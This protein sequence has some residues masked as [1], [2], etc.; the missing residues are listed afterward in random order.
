MKYNIYNLPNDILYYCLDNNIKALLGLTCSFFKPLLDNANKNKENEINEECK[1]VLDHY[2]MPVTGHNMMMYR[3]FS[4][5]IYK[6]NLLNEAYIK[7]VVNFYHQTSYIELLY[8]NETM[9]VWQSNEIIFIRIEPVKYEKIYNEIKKIISI[10]TRNIYTSN[11][12][13]NIRFIRNI[14]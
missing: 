8:K 14:E 11:N 12:F 1:S 9:K 3:L 6:N 2:I 10:K 5:D 4:F 13:N 7:I